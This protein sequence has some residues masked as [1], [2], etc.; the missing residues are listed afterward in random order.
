LAAEW[1]AHPKASYYLVLVP[2]LLLTGLGLVMVLSA[3]GV[4]A[5]TRY[6]GDAFY[7]FIRQGIF[8]VIGLV[9][10]AVMSRL[11]RGGIQV[12]GWGL[13]MGGMV[14]QLLVLVGHGWEKN[15]NTNWLDLGAGLPRVQ[16]SELLKFAL[17]C[18][19][20]CVF[21][22]KVK[23]LGEPRHVV[24]PF[25]P[26]SAVLIL[27]IA[28]CNDLGTAVVVGGIMLAILLVVGAHWK[29]I[30][31]ISAVAVVGAATL[32]AVSPNR[33]G[34]IFGFA[35][36][37][38]DTLGANHQPIKAEF[39]MASGGWWGTGL[40]SSKQKWGGLVEAHTDYMLAIIGEEL[41]LVCILAVLALFL[42]LG[43][44]G[45]RIAMRNTEPLYR[46]LAA[47]VTCWL[48]IEALANILVV[49]RML[50]VFGVPLPFLSYGGSALISNMLGIGV[51][52]ACAKQ[53][54]GAL[55]DPTPRRRLLRTIFPIRAAS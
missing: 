6:D 44:A 22:N 7:Y 33:M 48:M 23:V 38:S 47:G 55:A 30:A 39:A 24:V 15:G 51:L 13:L 20:A 54:P 31:S 53:E 49:L 1:L 41:G 17:V 16:P 46:F 25:V 42:V 8:A 12:A 9:C 14:L 50:P 19:A 4:D 3:S 35:D 29:I 26:V 34:R 18:W 40:G 45:F 36:Q 11:R 21:A 52:L 2:V 28:L 43:Y 27:M 37:T 5:Y 32:I 10:M